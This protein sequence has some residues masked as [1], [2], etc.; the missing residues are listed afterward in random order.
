[1]VWQSYDAS[2]RSVRFEVVSFTDDEIG[3][4]LVTKRIA[5]SDNYAVEEVSILQNR[6][7]IEG[8]LLGDTAQQQWIN[9]KRACEQKGSGDFQHPYF[10][11]KIKVHAENCSLIVDESYQDT[12]KFR[13]SFL[14][15]G[16]PIFERPRASAVQDFGNLS[17]KLR[18]S[19]SG[20]LERN[21]VLKGVSEFARDG[22]RKP[23]LG[24]NTFLR[25]M[26]SSA[27]FAENLVT[28]TGN[29]NFSNNL[30]LLN[31]AIASVPSFSTAADI[32]QSVSTTLSYMS[33]ISTNNNTY[34]SE[35]KPAILKKPKKINTNTADGANH[36]QNVIAVD[37][38]VKILILAEISDSVPDLVFESY[39]E[40]IKFKDELVT[41][42]AVM[43]EPDQEL[44]YDVS[45]VV[46]DLINKVAFHLPEVAEDL[47]NVGLIENVKN[48]NIVDVL[49][50]NNITKDDVESVMKRNS[51]TN[52]MRIEKESIE[53]LV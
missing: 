16:L 38:A 25:G 15:A 43:N 3:R 46:S 36:N 44:E 28:G 20:I 33:Q 1:M 39:E 50:A 40:A 48:R 26:L 42:I 19:A 51:I 5:G 31:T 9:L 10:V 29:V 17:T 21:A 34:V 13:I 24:L 8:L 2:F 41:T 23:I 53:V 45:L 52:P 49:Y 12:I 6:F 4:V 18:A 30:T 27:R 35:F 14:K 32:F 22:A 47:P 11:G 37:S 7:T